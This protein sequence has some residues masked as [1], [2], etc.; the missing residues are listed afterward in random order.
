MPRP[1]VSGYT[2][3]D[4]SRL[5]GVTEGR[6]RAFVRAGFVVPGRDDRGRFVFTF[7][8]L[9]VL[10]TAQGLAASRVPLR[11]LRRVL[12]QLVAEL[13][14]GRTLASVRIRAHGQQVVVQR[15]G[16]VW[17][18]ESGQ[19]LLA[20]E[21]D[22]E[23]GELARKA[24]PLAGRFIARAERRRTPPDHEGWFELGL[25]LEAS[26]PLEAERAY[27]R[28]LELQPGDAAS[29]LNLGRLLHERG[30]L[31]EAEGFYRAALDRE[32]QSP[33]AAFNLGVALQDLGRLAEAARAYRRALELDP[34]YA[35]AHFNLAGVHERRGEGAEA[36]RHLKDYR[37]LRGRWI[38]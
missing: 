20:F 25:D 13:P 30:E 7:Q 34:G 6:T 15:G 37:E 17:E 28:A 32:P 10:R 4:V 2:T 33:T 12:A 26:A 31:A 14:R 8:D 35:D 38:S 1:A 24:A 29:A 18:P 19:R 5:L 11:R 36:I 3:R 16:E 22:F 9:V 23:V 27:R 21:L